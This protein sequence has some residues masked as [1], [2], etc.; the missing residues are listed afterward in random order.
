VHAIGGVDID[1]SIVDCA[2]RSLFIWIFGSVGGLNRLRMT[3]AV[4]GHAWVNWT[5]VRTPA[6]TSLRSSNWKPNR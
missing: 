3:D 6:G 4:D 5:D 1:G 2:A